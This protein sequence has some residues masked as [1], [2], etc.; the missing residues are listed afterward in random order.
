MKIKLELSE[1]RYQLV[2]QQLIDLGIEI[3]D[4]ADLILMERE[5][6]VDYLMVVS[7]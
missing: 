5:S 7:L 4:T 1:S 2:R 6:F 3:D